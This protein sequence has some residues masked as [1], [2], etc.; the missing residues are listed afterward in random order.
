MLAGGDVGERVTA[1][2]LEQFTVLSLST[3]PPSPEFGGLGLFHLFLFQGSFLLVSRVRLLLALTPDL[4]YPRSPSPSFQQAAISEPNLDP[5][6]VNVRCTWGLA[7][8]TSEY[9]PSVVFLLFFFLSEQ[10]ME[11]ERKKEKKPLGSGSS[12]GELP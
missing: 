1:S 9:Y 7:K 6:H 12:S 3:P 2:H 10:G 4:G 8:P 5:C 11:K